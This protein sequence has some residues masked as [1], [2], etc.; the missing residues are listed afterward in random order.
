MLRGGRKGHSSPPLSTA[1]NHPL[2]ALPSPPSNHNMPPPTHL[3]CAG[4]PLR[5]LPLA[6][7]LNALLRP[8]SGLSVFQIP[9]LSGSHGRKAAVGLMRLYRSRN[10]AL[11]ASDVVLFAAPRRWSRRVWRGVS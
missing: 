11:G 1:I 5:L 6:I 9:A 7:G 4:L 2:Q 10:R 8:A 3:S